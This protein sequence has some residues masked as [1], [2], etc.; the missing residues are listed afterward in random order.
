MLELKNYQKTCLEQLQSYIQ[1]A[2]KHGAKAAFVLQT[3]RLYR[4]VAVLP[5][6]PYVCLRVP[7]GGG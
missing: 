7:T 4:E 3:E 6:I 5:Q 1:L 2:N